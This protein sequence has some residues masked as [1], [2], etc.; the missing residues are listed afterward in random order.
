LC[1]NASDGYFRK[2]KMIIEKE[3]F[4]CT[5][6]LTAGLL[7]GSRWREKLADQ[8][9]LDTRNAKAAKMLAKLADETPTLSD[10]YWQLLKPYFNSDPIRWRDALSNASRQVGFSYGKTGFPY[11]VRGLISILNESVAA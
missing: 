6:S 11:F 10:S 9:P 1:V 8:Y 7:K 3:K 5:E 4:D 2:L